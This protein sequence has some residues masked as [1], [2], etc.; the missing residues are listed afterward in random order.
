MR[1]D[2]LFADLE[3]QTQALLVAERD[4]EVAELTRLETS[5]LQLVNRLRPAVGAA[6]RVRCLGGMALAGRIS[7]V[8]AGWLLLDEG[9]GREAL[10]AAAAV[11]SVAG[12]G[13]LSAVPGSALD[14]GLGIG[15]A[16]RA[17]ARDRSVLRA[18]LTDSTVLDGTLDRVGSDFVDFAVHAAGEP[19]R[20]EDVREILVLPISALAALRR[21]S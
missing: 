13:R 6:V 10:L 3:A 17:V 20:R 1:W 21:D 19:R 2:D 9:G 15:H 14:G 8:G 11:T 12:L 7:A 5:R 4:A 18:C 16:L